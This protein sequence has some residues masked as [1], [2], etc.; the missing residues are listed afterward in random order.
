MSEHFFFFFFFLQGGIN[1]KKKNYFEL[2]GAKIADLSVG[3]AP[4]V[5]ACVRRPAAARKGRCCNRGESDYNDRSSN[6]PRI[7]AATFNESLLTHSWHE[8]NE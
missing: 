5:D 8:K 4:A 7:T 3:A 6:S 1:S 2:F